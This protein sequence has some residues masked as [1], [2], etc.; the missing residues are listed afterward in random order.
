MRD[1][2]KDREFDKFRPS[3]ADKSKVAVV[4]EQNGPIE[5]SFD[6]VTETQAFYGEASAVASGASQDVLTITVP[7]DKKISIR[8]IFCSGDNIAK[9]FILKDS[10]TV[11]QIR[12]YY[13]DF[14][15]QLT[16]FSLHLNAGSILKVRVENFRPSIAD[17]NATILGDISE[18]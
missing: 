13:P 8:S 4:L 5:V 14:N 11:A 7:V 18:I 1:N 2:T 16:N 10:E 3:G 6:G 17:F 9:F 12:T 15:F